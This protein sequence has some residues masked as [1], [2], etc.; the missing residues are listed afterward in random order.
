MDWKH[1]TAIQVDRRGEDSNQCYLEQKMDKRFL[2]SSRRRIFL[3]TRLTVF[4]GWAGSVSLKFYIWKNLWREESPYI[5]YTHPK[6][7]IALACYAIPM[8]LELGLSFLLL[9][10]FMW[11]HKV[12]CT[13]LGYTRV[14]ISARCKNTFVLVQQCTMLQSVR[15][16]LTLNN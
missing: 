5:M 1:S 14:E 3:W 4:V 13:I 7:I 10:L 15:L 6:L 12:F 16:I 2:Q 9:L 8:H 11:S